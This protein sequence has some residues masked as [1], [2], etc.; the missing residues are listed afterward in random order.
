MKLYFSRSLLPLCEMPTLLNMQSMH[1]CN[2]VQVQG[3]VKKNSKDSQKPFRTSVCVHV[4]EKRSPASTSLLRYIP[5]P[6]LP[7]LPKQTLECKKNEASSKSKSEEFPFSFISF[8]MK[9]GWRGPC[10]PPSRTTRWDTS[11]G[12]ISSALWWRAL[13]ADSD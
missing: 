10:R 2:K 5:H 11:R 6:I 1:N 4:E 3:C 12:E 7:P 9:R 13:L 8:C